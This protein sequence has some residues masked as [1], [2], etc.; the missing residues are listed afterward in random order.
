[1][2]DHFYCLLLKF[3]VIVKEEL[4]SKELNKELLFLAKKVKEYSSNID[5]TKAA[6]FVP[7]HEHIGY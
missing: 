2:I 4:I 6:G 7:L 3:I 5:Q 1:M